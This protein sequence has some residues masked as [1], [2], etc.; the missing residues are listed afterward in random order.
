MILRDSIIFGNTPSPLGAKLTPAPVDKESKPSATN[1]SPVAMAKAQRFFN[2]PP[3]LK[4]EDLLIAKDSDYY[5]YDLKPEAFDRDGK[6]TIDALIT[7]VNFIND[8]EHP[9]GNA[10]KESTAERTMFSELNA[11]GDAPKGRRIRILAKALNKVLDFK[12]PGNGSGTDFFPGLVKSLTKANPSLGGLDLEILSNNAPSD[13][14]RRGFIEYVLKIA[15]NAAQKGG[16][17]NLAKAIELYDYTDLHRLITNIQTLS[18]QSQ[19]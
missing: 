17:R 7:M 14:A 15:A 4:I 19:Q 2:E 12:N 11:E 5:D 3:S 6:I 10:T 13:N 8:K 9:L 1:S 16:N 18:K